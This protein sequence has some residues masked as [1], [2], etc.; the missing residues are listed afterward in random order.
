MPYAPSRSNRKE[1]KKKNK[2][3]DKIVSSEYETECENVK[4]LKLRQAI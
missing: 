2:R 3:E 1:R 4:T